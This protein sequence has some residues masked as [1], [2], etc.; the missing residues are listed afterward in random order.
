MMLNLFKSNRCQICYSERQVRECPRKKKKIGWACCNEIRCDCSCPSVC[1]YASKISD[2]DFFPSFKADSRTESEQVSKLHID[3]WIARPH[4]ALDMQSPKALATSDPQKALA[5]LSGFQY[6]HSFPLAYLMD[7]L[8][9]KHE[10]YPVEA[11]P[12]QIAEYYLNSLIKLDYSSLRQW[13]INQSALPDLAERYAEIISEVPALAKIGGFSILHSG[14]G[15][16]GSTALV[17]VELNHKKDWTFVLTNRNGRWQL[18]QNLAG[19]PQLYYGQNQIYNGIAEALGKAKDAE[20][21]EGLENAFRNYPDSADL[22]YY[23]ALYWQLVKQPDKATVDFFNAVALDNAWPEPYFH[24]GAI[25]M[26][27]KDY[28]QAIL[29]LKELAGLAPDNPNALNNL[30]AAYA[31]SGNTGMAKEMWQEIETR[32]PGFSLAT[33]N[34]ARLKELQ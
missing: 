33:Q 17:F 15:E 10:A 26:A 3:L 14:L 11:D 31:A 12:E 27:K 5:W 34:L 19:S 24:L 4:P 28:E 20:A 25:Y 7:K 1:P 21:W 30:A 6:P 32:F 13:T 23:R 22:Y 9:L 2:A 29:W 18:R 8:G 16:D